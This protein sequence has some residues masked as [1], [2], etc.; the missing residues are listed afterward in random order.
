MLITY[1]MDCNTCVREEEDK[2]RKNRL[3]KKKSKFGTQYFEDE[4]RRKSVLHI[5]TV[6]VKIAASA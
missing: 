4:N 1:A 6:P 2:N 5:A 3:E